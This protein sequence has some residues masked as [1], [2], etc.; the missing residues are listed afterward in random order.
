MEGP[1]KRARLDDCV[2][3]VDEVGRE[4]APAGWALGWAVAVGSLLPRAPGERKV[5]GLLTSLQH[6]PVPSTPQTAPQTLPLPLPR[7]LP[8]HM[9]MHPTIPA[10]PVAATNRWASKSGFRPRGATPLA[11]CTSGCTASGM[12]VAVRVDFESDRVPVPIPASELGHACMPLECGPLA[13]LHGTP[14]AQ[15]DGV[16]ES[17]LQ[18][19]RAP[20]QAGNRQGGA[21]PGQA[22]ESAQA[23]WQAA[24]TRIDSESESDPQI[25]V[26]LEVAA[27]EHDDT[28]GGFESDAE[29]QCMPPMDVR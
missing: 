26:Q 10:L 25:R 2:V 17:L 3:G 23:H 22:P 5:T 20:T 21:T 16:V 19:L 12:P 11:E 8:L 15:L 27:S 14:R 13:P 9:P 29:L 18:T 28:A 24:A 4:Q 1:W 7:R 6:V